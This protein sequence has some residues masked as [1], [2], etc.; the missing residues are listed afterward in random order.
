VLAIDN[1]P[2][3]NHQEHGWLYCDGYGGSVWVRM[4]DSHLGWLH[5]KPEAYPIFIQ[6]SN[7]HALRYELGTREPRRFFDLD[8]QSWIELPYGAPILGSE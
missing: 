8:T 4:W 6:V 1:Y 2:W 5:T 3:I 7:G